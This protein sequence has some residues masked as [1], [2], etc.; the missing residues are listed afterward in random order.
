MSRMRLPQGCFIACQR[1]LRAL[2]TAGVNF[3]FYPAGMFQE[4]CAMV[5]S[6]VRQ[7]A[8]APR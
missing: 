1:V 5:S 2:P 4:T 6:L 8:I 7:H 3:L